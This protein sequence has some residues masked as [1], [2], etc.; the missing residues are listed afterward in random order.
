VLRAI[1]VAWQLAM[2]VYMQDG[3]L[4]ERGVVHFGPLQTQN[5]MIDDTFFEHRPLTVTTIAL[6]RRRE[7]LSTCNRVT[8]K[9]AGTLAVS[10]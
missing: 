8:V 5:R 10:N 7:R 2:G 1:F 4:E 6:K 3:S 9:D